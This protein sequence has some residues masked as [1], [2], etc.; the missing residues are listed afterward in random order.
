M[1]QLDFSV[2]PSQFF[3]LSISFFAMLFI[4]S[5]II[6]PK[7]AEMINL[8]QEKIDDYL[9]KA[10]DIKGKAEQAI[11]KYQEAL[12]SATEEANQ[13]LLKTQQELKGM[14]ERRQADLAEELKRQISDGERKI[15]ASKEKVM[16][17]VQEMAG[18]LAL[19]VVKKLGFTNIK[20]EDLLNAV[21]KAGKE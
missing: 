3:W 17:Q 15:Q 8:R 16:K 5:K 7:I 10:A 2:F 9:E 19:D 1:P 11:D 14:I 20:P 18:D 12:R 6:I 13:S 4:M 21:K